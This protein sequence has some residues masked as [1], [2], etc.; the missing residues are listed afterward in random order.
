MGISSLLR[1]QAVKN[2]FVFT[3]EV[4]KVRHHFQSRR[5]A[6][7]SPNSAYNI[8]TTS[9]HS[10]YI[11]LPQ[12]F[13]SEGC[14]ST[15]FYYLFSLVLPL[16]ICNSHQ[17]NL[18]STSNAS[19]VALGIISNLNATRLT[20]HNA[21]FDSS[22]I[23]FFPA[24]KSDCERA[25]DKLVIGKSLIK[26]HTFGYEGPRLT[27]HLP[28]N[29]EYG[30]CSITLMTFDLHSRITI[31]YAEIYSELLGPDGVL[32]ECLGPSVPADEAFGGQT[33][34]GPENMLVADVSGLLKQP[35]GKAGSEGSADV[36]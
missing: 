13:V 3:S 29:A 21:C 12:P 4:S 30:S 27:D 22:E 6:K 7:K 26:P 19:T 18:L 31:T 36:R 35:T 33:A 1:K 9:I 34:I 16:V 25:L 17:L 15:M 10:W 8:C 32:K 11:F 23:Q 14:L 28:V 24:T 2:E 5:I 20:T